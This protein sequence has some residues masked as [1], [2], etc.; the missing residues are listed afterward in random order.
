MIQAASEH[1]FDVVLAKTQSRFTRKDMEL[2]KHRT[3]SLLRRFGSLLSLTMW[4]QTILR[5]K[6]LCQIN[7]LI[8]EWYLED[9]VYQCPLGA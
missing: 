3:E 1:K 9:F 5:I 8:N 4:I 7:G 6:N 2:G